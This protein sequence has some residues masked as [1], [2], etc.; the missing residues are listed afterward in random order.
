M[1]GPGIAK[2]S[3]FPFVTSMVDLGP[4]MLELADGGFDNASVPAYMDGMSFAPMLTGQGER[5]WKGAAL[6]EYLSIREK[7]TVAICEGRVNT[8]EMATYMD[9]Y[10]YYINATGQLQL[11][12]Q[13]DHF[14]DGPNNT[15][16]AL[17]IVDGNANLLYAEF[18]DVR[19]PKAWDFAPDQLNFFELYN[20]SEDYYMRNNIYQSVSDQ[21]RDKL[22]RMLQTTIKCKG[23]AQC[24]ETLKKQ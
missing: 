6:V 4:T 1:E 5:P 13:N 17:R 19:N 9:A 7:D 2:G 21:M 20:V 18:A 3:I 11:C 24:F 16:S 22:H 12:K 10:G 23:N 8:Q 15:F 14:H